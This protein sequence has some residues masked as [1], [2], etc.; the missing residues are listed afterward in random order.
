MNVRRAATAPRRS[1]DPRVRAWIW[2]T[3]IGLVVYLGLVF[4]IGWKYAL[5]AT[6]VYLAADIVFRSKTMSVVPAA[7]QVTAA[8]RSTRNRLKV[9]Q[10]AGYIALNARVI[11]GKDSII[12]HLVVGPAGIFAIDSEKWDKRLPLRAIGGMLYHGPSSMEARLAH[13]RDEAHWAAALIGNALGRTIRVH[14]VMIIYGPA[15]PWVVMKLKGVDV[16][17]GNHTGTYF[18]KL[19]RA[20]AR[21]HLTQEQIAALIATAERVLPALEQS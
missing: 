15:V 6:V 3:A 8:Q 16:F 11:P 13:A 14:P 18:R 4:W 5:T 20:T 7:T 17:A 12:D 19:S 2:R 9:L 1:A 21:H 10:A